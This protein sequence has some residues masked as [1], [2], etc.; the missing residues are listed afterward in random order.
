MRR[1]VPWL[2][3]C[4]LTAHS[5]TA[6]DQPP[7]NHDRKQAAAVKVA[8][9]AIRVDGRLD[10]E[11]WLRA[12]PVADFVQKEPTEGAAPSDAMEVRFLYDDNALFVGARMSSRDG[13]IQAPLARRDTGDTQAEYILISLDT[14]LDRRTAYDFGVTASGVRLDRYHS[15]DREDVLDTDYNPVWRAETA[16][17]ADGW[18]AELWIPLSQLRFNP[19]RDQVWGLNIRRFRPTLDEDDYW[20]L[21]PRTERVYA[22]RFGELRGITGIPPT[23]RVELL[24][25][26]AGAST[27]HSNRDFR[28][29]F[30]DGRNLASRVGA[31]MKMGLGSNL[32]L[33][34]SVNPDFGQV[35]AD[36]AEVNLSAFETRFPEKRPFF[37]EGAQLLNVNHPNFFYS[38]RI[39]ARP[40]GAAS[41]DFVDYPSSS[42]ILAAAKLTGRLPSKTSIGILSAV[43]ASESARVFDLDA[44]QSARLRV[45]PRTVYALARVQQEFGELGST[46]GIHLTAVHRQ[47]EADDPLAALLSRH[48]FTAAGDTVLRFKRGEYE[49]RSVAGAAF[50][51]GEPGAIERIQRSS[52]HYAQRPDK[53]YFLFDP[54]RTSL[55]GFT[56]DT[57]FERTGGRHWVWNAGIKV[58]TPAFESND[59]AQLIAGDGIM[60]TF[61]IRYRETQPGRFLRAYSVGVN[62]SNEWSFGGHHNSSSLRQTTNLTWS[63][64]WTTVVSITRTLRVLD[65]ALTRGG[66]LME[67]PA[68]WISAVTVGN[69]ASSPTRLSATTTLG[70]NEDGGVQ[71]R[72][73]GTFSFRPGP[74]WE[75]SVAPFY[76][77]LVDPQQ[78]VVTAAGGMQAT[79]GSRYVFSFIDRSTIS[80]AYRLGFTL[81]PDMNLD[82]YAEPFASS[83]RY[84]DFGEL[85]A[86]G[87]RARLTYGTGATSITDLPD[88]S[89]AVRVGDAAFTLTA[90]DFNVRSFRSN[91]VLRWEWRPGSTLYAVW[92]E[93]RSASEVLGSR[94]GV[95]DMF[96]SLTAPGSH[97]FVVK[98]SFWLPVK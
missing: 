86:A 49:L 58:D 88:G 92:Q 27:V 25:Y 87:T 59:I 46:A 13:A 35:E 45:A 4:A 5:A 54:A 79:F 7:A 96:R 36:P 33:D 76:E 69:R 31:D 89:R 60:P 83:G 1:V 84:Y 66:P 3:L 22:S 12:S 71:R 11:A 75:L 97:F 62:G 40:R 16:I 20:V 30:D 2:M 8:G 10:E 9:G 68:G 61:D 14:F 63:N 34:A 64:Y 65:S 56:N 15:T 80:A 74:R 55:S 38:R 21:V 70:G 52:S 51:D 42:T 53:N 44:P 91:V 85:V 41:G 47:F 24:P 43:T 95:G 77:R 23:R 48:A 26:V 57:R 29:P 81:R 93:D 17:S 73:N 28:N 50:V 18:T 32:T 72:V 6:Q 98:T 67:R 78:Y 94:I 37:T 82:V 39:G 19:G 90:R